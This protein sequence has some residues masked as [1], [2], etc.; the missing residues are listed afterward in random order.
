MLLQVSIGKQLKSVLDLD[1]TAR[2]G[3][4]THVSRSFLQIIRSK[5]KASS[6]GIEFPSNSQAVQST[7]DKQE[8]L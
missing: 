2:L 7:L 6:I 3:F 5:D 4:T 8:A 1:P